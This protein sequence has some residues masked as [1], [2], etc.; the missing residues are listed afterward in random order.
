MEG[1]PS[2]SLFLFKL[3]THIFARFVLQSHSCTANSD[4]QKSDPISVLMHILFQIS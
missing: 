3:I 2:I 4:L 1:S